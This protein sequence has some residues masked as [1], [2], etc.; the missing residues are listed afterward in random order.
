MRILFLL[1]FSSIGFAS[2]IEVKKDPMQVKITTER[3]IIRQIE[4]K[5]ISQVI[6]L[7]QEPQNRLFYA[8]GPNHI[9][10][11]A[12][13]QRRCQDWIERFKKNNPYSALTITT[14]KG[15][16]LGFVILGFGDDPRG[17]KDAPGFSEFNLIIDYSH[18][19]K[20]YGKEVSQVIIHDW[21]LYL[22][23]RG[24]LVNGARLR[25]V[26]ATSRSDNEAMTKILRAIKIPYKKEHNCYWLNL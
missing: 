21:A 14:K 7:M 11:R 16:Y 9:P 2:Q 25:S 8:K 10:S 20:G 4:E 26:I 23:K 24:Y 5:D 17:K 15:V 13:I 19:G 18:W 12:F 1:I 3:L 6:K 22:K